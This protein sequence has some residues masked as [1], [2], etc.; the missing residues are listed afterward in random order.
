M[1]LPKKL[2]IADVSIEDFYA[3]K[4]RSLWRGMKQEHFSF[5]ALVAYFLFE[6]VRPQSIY[7]VIEIIPWGQL[8]FIAALFGA[9]SDRSVRWVSCIENKLLFSFL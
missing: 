9:F 7:P 2:K 8:C 4:L 1:K 3:V 5:W 6:Y